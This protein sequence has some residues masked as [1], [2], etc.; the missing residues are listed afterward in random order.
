[1]P[2]RICVFLHSSLISP[3]SGPGALAAC[4]FGRFP[5]KACCKL[6]ASITM[7]INHNGG[8]KFSKMEKK[9]LRKQSKAIHML[10]KHEGIQ[11]VSYP[12]QSL[13][14]ANGG[15]GNGVSRKQLLLALEKCGP[16]EALLT[17]P[18]K[19]GAF[20]IYKT[21]EESKKAYA[22]L[23]GKEIIDDL[24]Q[25]IILYLNFVEK[26]QWKKLGLQALPPGLLVVEESVSSE[27]EKNAFGK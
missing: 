12:T 10:L 4:G 13:V 18:N 2:P 17:P 16:M 20:V 22:T 26:A 11:A 6:Y 15:L 23:N 25:K 14:I 7:N 8:L 21:V 27:D 24:G 5:V 9:F 1:M 19:P 3:A